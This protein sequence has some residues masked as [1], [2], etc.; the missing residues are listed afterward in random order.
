MVEIVVVMCFI[1]GLMLFGSI[2]YFWRFK[3]E[4]VTRGPG[5]PDKYYNR[6]LY[7]SVPG[8]LLFVG[9]ALSLFTYLALKAIGWV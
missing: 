5:A 1:G 2:Y 8:L 6:A 3:K 9:N 4:P 7:L